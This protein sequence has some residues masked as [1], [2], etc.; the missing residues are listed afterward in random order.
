MSRHWHEVWRE[1]NATAFTVAQTTRQFGVVEQIHRGLLRTLRRGETVEMF[2]ARLEP[3]LARLGWTPPVGRAGD[4]PRRLRRIY[5]TNLRTAHAAGQWDR[6][7]RTKDLLPY[8]V[9]RLGPSEVHRDAHQAWAGVCLPVGDPWW[10]THYP[11]NGW[12]CRCYV[13]QVAEPPDGAIT[14]R[15]KTVTKEWTRPGATRPIDVPVGIDPGWDYNAAQHA[16]LGPHQGLCRPDRAAAGPRP[17]DAKP[18]PPPA[19]LH[20]RARPGPGLRVVRGA[21]AGQTAAEAEDTPGRG[22]SSACARWP[23]RS[24]CWR[25]PSDAC[26]KPSRRCSS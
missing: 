25:R 18:G 14:R 23:P 13:Q 17:G 26:C 2:R 3:A 8:L 22:A 9:Y 11:P 24:P 21:R 10:N 7:Q 4:V 16:A 5:D 1:A 12:G 20:L 15:P 19:A 6:I